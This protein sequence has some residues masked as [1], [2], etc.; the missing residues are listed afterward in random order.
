[1]PR[2]DP[3]TIAQLIQV[4]RGDDHIAYWDAERDLVAA[5]EPAVAPLLD[6]LADLSPWA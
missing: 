5:G 4:L 2:T 3:S 1:M 6:V